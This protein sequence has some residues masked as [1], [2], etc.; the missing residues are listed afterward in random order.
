MKSKLLVVAVLALVFAIK[1]AGQEKKYKALYLETGM[2]FIACSPPDDKDYIRG[3]VN[4]YSYYYYE[5]SY[6][7]A[8]SYKNYLG[9]KVEVKIMNDLLGLLGGIRFTRMVNSIGKNDY[10]S[11]R[12][13]FLYLLYQQQGTTTE[14]LKVKD[15]TQVSNYV[16]IPLELRIYPYRQ[17]TIQMYFKFGADF[18]MLMTTNTKVN[19]VDVNMAQYEEGVDGIIEDPWSFYST[20]HLAVG[21]K[22]GKAEKPG[23]NIEA[24]VP[25]FI[26]ANTNSSFVLPIAGGGIQLNIRIPF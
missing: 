10:W 6:M 13:D 1:S 3:D 4:P 14:Y 23:F 21:M 16:G 2:D 11:T 22:I 19:F 25:S 17:R 9:A 8:L 18:N 7:K 20:L 24:C 12:S 26:L 5:T 15:I